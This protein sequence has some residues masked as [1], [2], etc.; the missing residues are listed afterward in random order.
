MNRRTIVFGADYLVPRLFLFCCILPAMRTATAAQVNPLD[1]SPAIQA[2]LNL[3]ESPGPTAAAD[4]PVQ[5]T[6]TVTG[7]AG[8]PTGTVSYT[9]DGT[10]MESVALANGVA[11]FSL[12]GPQTQGAHIVS[13]AYNGDKT[14]TV[15]SVSQGFTLTVLPPG[16]ATPPSFSVSASSES[17]TVSAGGEVQ[18][19]LT[20]TPIGGYTG[21]LQYAC[22]GI[23]LATICGFGTESA[24]FKTSQDPISVSLTIIPN[25]PAASKRSPPANLPYLAISL[26]GSLSL[27]RAFVRKKRH[28]YLSQQCILFFLSFFLLE[29]ITACGG[30][31]FNAKI[32]PTPQ[33]PKGT[34]AVMGT[35]IGSGGITQSVNISLTVK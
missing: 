19:L 34:Y 13:V 27:V 17:G 29:T 15:P 20:L 12:P 10:G 18:F 23:P 2:V 1:T 26:F 24:P 11:I 31:F 25:S 4:T 6:A 21:T 7:A 35:I 3:T 33:A 9:I 30:K 16:S 14:Y 8:I 32:P 28:P 22:T 5:V